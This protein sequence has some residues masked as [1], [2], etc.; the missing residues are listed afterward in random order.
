ME[1]IS[2]RTSP[3]F[4]FFKNIQY[5]SSYTYTGTEK[6]REKNNSRRRRRGV[7]SFSYRRR[8]VILLTCRISMSPDFFVGTVGIYSADGLETVKT[9]FGG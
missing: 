4:F 2:G 7:I 8:T 3:D 9:G 6:K 1:I 5:Y